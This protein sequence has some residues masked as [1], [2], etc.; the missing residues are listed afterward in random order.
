MKSFLSRFGSA[1]LFILSGFDRLRLCGESTLLNHMGG[2]HSYCHQQRI[3][4]KDFP[5]HAESLTKTFRARSYQFAGEVPLRHLDR[6]TIDKEAMAVQ[7]AHEHGR[8]HGRIA[9]L[10]CQESGQTYRPR[11]NG[12]GLIELRKETTRCTHYYHYFLHEQFGLCYVRIQSWFPFTVRVGLNG[13]RWLIQ[14]LRQRGVFCEARDNLVTAVADPLLA[15]HLL[16]E[17]VRV[18]WS[19]LL[20]GLVQPVHPLWDYLY[21]D[22]VHTPFHWMT[23]QSEWATDIVFAEPDFMTVWYPR[24]I[25]HG[26]ETLSCKDVLRYLGKHVPEQGYGHCR[27]EAKIDLRTRIEGARLKFWYGSNQLKMYDKEA[28][29]ANT[30]RVETTI[31]DPSG[32]KVFRTKQGEDAAAPKSWQQMR[33]SVD[34]LPRRAEVSQSAN[35][36]LAESLATVAEPT[37]LGKLLEPLGRPVVGANGRRVARALNPLTGAD[38]DLLRTLA[39]GDYLLHGFRNRDLRVTKFGDGTAPVERRRQAAKITRLLGLLRAHDLILKVHKTHRYQLTAQGRR[40]CTA[41]LAAHQADTTR[42]TQ[43]A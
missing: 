28:P 20:E 8:T 19:A 22:K 14:Q 32:F 35:Q 13:R 30:L 10:T 37:P 40:I 33:K 7:L 17:Q 41:L 3:L 12:Q 25:R 4:F 39:Q 21:D 42:L 5:K 1:I 6:P 16:D 15:Q 23:E 43:A 34:D 18:D 2:V 38:G 29:L 31:N 24:W 36:R 26:I 9:L 27:G 11:R